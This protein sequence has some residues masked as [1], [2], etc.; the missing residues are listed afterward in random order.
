MTADEHSRI[1]GI[2]NAIFGGL[3]ALAG[4][5]FLAIPIWVRFTTPA[6]QEDL[7]FDD[8]GFF[9]VLGTFFLV[10]GLIPFTVGIALMQHR[11]WA[12]VGGIITAILFIGSFPL[13]TALGVY[14]LV[15]MFSD[16]GR[17]FYLN[18]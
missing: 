3:I 15:F 14:T 6:G 18:S 8:L 9:L 1:L 7:V 5:A 13:G 10:L 4:L 16:R 17:Q 11:S 2:S 12:R